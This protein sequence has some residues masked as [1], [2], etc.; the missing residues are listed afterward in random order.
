MLDVLAVAN[1]VHNI[2]L[3]YSS[4]SALYHTLSQQRQS[5]SGRCAEADEIY[6]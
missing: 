1:L 5:R 3:C 2:D 4:V 6:T